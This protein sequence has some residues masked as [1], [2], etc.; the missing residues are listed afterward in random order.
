MF[1]ACLEAS[2]FKVRL[3]GSERETHLRLKRSKL[4]DCSHQLEQLQYNDL[5]KIAVHA[6]EIIYQLVD[7]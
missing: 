2:E 1:T 6:P 5:F 4:G 3:L 7:L